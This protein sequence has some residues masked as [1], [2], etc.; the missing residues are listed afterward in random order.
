MSATYLIACVVMALCLAVIA[1]TLLRSKRHAREQ[2]SLGRAFER[3]GGR[4]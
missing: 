3:H 1:V 2:Q 4:S